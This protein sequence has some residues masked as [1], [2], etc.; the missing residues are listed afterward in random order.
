MLKGTVHFQKNLY[1]D[2][3]YYFLTI[4]ETPGKRIETQESINGTYPLISTYD[5]TVAYEEDLEKIVLSYNDYSGREWYGEQFSPGQSLN[6]SFD[7]PGIQENSEIEIITDV[8]N[9]A[10]SPASFEVSLNGKGL[11][12]IPTEAIADGTYTRKG[13]EAQKKFITNAT[14]GLNPLIVSPYL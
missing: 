5:E 11:G 4:G 12:T 9:T 1:S 6:F 3:T 8:L 14:T 13:Q 10:L 7:L 2:T